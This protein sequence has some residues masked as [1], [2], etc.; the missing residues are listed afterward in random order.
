MAD[1]LPPGLFR[2]LEIQVVQDVLATANGAARKAA[3]DDLGQGGEVGRDT[4]VGLRPAGGDP[5]TGNHLVEDQEGAVLTGQRPQLVQG[6]DGRR[7]LARVAADR[8]NH[9]GG[10]IAIAGQDLAYQFE[11]VRRDEDDL[12]G[13]L[14]VDPDAGR[15]VEMGVDPERHVVVPAMKMPVEADDLRPSGEGPGETDGHVGGLGARGMEAHPLGTGNHLL[16]QPA[17]AHFQLVAGAEMGPLFH[18]AL[19]RF[20]DLGPAVAEQHGPV[21][22]IEIDIFI[23]VDVPLSRSL[24]VVGVDPVGPHVPRIVGQPARQLLEGL[25]RQFRRPG[26]H[27]PVCGLNIRV[28]EGRRHHAPPGLV[29][30]EVIVGSS[31][32]TGFP[33][34]FGTSDPGF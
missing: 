13:H 5:K 34:A 6:V 23:V 22:A 31:G 14:L 21:A 28:G 26:R 30:R 25:A 1:L 10:Y 11:V 17:P 4:V 20:L 18:L 16:D 12:P 2:D 8:L 9:H 3:S 24:G 27:R 19:H 29:A 33:V 7:D 15:T 32:E